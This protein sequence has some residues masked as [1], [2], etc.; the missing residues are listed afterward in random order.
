VSQADLELRRSIMPEVVE[1]AKAAQGD[2]VRLL[3]S[4]TYRSYAYQRVVYDREV[5]MYGKEMA[6]R[7]S[8]VPGRSQ[9][10]L[11][12]AIDFGSITDA[13]AGTS[14]ARWL[15]AHAWEY[16]FSLSYPQGY[17]ALTGY[18]WES[19]HYRYIT[20]PGARMQREY[21]D[22]VQQY[23]LLFLHDERP[24]LLAHREQSDHP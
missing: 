6:D 16:G 17:E 3:F 11:G 9:H 23:L 22:D 8:A 5:Q 14:E 18:R 10:Q 21:F 19:W 20:K 24:T 13:F 15:S 2:G 4:S 7:E 1:M 12:T